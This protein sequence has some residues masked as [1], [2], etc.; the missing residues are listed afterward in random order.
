MSLKDLGIVPGVKAESFKKLAK[1]KVEEL[2]NF[3]DLQEKELTDIIGNTDEK[4]VTVWREIDADLMNF[5][6]CPDKMKWIRKKFPT[7]GSSKRLRSRVESDATP[8]NESE[9]GE[10]TEVRT[11]T[12]VRGD[13]VV[14]V[15]KIGDE[16]NTVRGEHKV[17]VEFDSNDLEKK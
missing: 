10:S 3:L 2:D 12:T 6:Q 13:D 7:T 11:A 5:V 9:K 17:A 1:A 15:D 14:V 8:F 4:L 16:S